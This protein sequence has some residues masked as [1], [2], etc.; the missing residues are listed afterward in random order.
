MKRILYQKEMKSCD[1]AT[2]TQFHIPESVLMERAALSVVRI[3]FEEGLSDKKILVLCGTGHN[4][5]D[6]LAIARLLKEKGKNVSFTLLGD[7]KNMDGLVKEQLLSARAYNTEELIFAGGDFSGFDVIIDAIFGIGLSRPLDETILSVIENANSANAIRIAVDMP[8]GVYTDTGEV[9]DTA[10]FADLTVTFGFAKVGQLLFP[11]RSFAGRLFIADIGI[12]EYSLPEKKEALFA[13]ED[14]DIRHYL[15]KRKADT[16]KGSYGK[17]LVVAGSFDCA[18]AAYFAAKAC[19]LCGAGM[20]R[21]LTHETNRS[22]LQSLIPEALLTTYQD[23][24]NEKDVLSALESADIVLMGPGLS[25]GK[26]GKQIFDIIFKNTSVPMVLD[27]DALNIISED[28]GILL[29]PHTELVLTP[30]IIEMSRLRGEGSSYIKENLIRI[31]E[32][33][34]REYQV[35]CHLKDSAS[36]TAIPFRETYICTSGNNGMATAGS[37]DVLSGI[38]AGLMA[39]GAPADVAASLGAYI[40]GK[41]GDISAESKGY[42]SL[43]ASDILDGIPEALSGNL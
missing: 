22:V 26:T 42:E 30:H 27:A 41:A 37:G 6:G 34:S 32:E 10:F 38:I 14:E 31:A 24:I 23:K 2:S 18:G 12:T 33:F 4:G 15:P 1:E 28:T 13:Y 19:Y 11:G 43:M 5:G 8:S 16:H 9:P 3:L 29:K 39:T 21:I 20:V 35:I 40:H 7:E 17:V 36:V 25:T